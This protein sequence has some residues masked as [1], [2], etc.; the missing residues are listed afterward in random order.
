MSSW[1]EIAIFGAF[2]YVSAS[3]VSKVL[4]QARASAPPPPPPAQHAPATPPPPPLS[5]PGPVLVK[6]SGP[7][8]IR[9]S[10]WRN[11]L[12]KGVLPGLILLF[13]LYRVQSG[14]G[15]GDVH[16]AATNIE[17]RLNDVIGL[18]E[19]KQEVR[20]LIDYLREPS[21]FESNGLQMPKGLLLFG[22]PGVGKTLLARAS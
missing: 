16:K 15:R 17:T 6:V 1:C 19:A 11:L 20:V 21:V 7:I 12:L 4:E 14:S 2:D 18:E 3:V 9:E 5:P 13:V 10:P 8:D 22:P